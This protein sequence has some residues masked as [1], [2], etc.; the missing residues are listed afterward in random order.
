MHYYATCLL[1]DRITADA[2]APALI[3]SDMVK[4]SEAAIPRGVSPRQG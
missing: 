4:D 3:A 1:A 2:I